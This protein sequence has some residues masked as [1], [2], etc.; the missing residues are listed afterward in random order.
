MKLEP[1]SLLVLVLLVVGGVLLYFG[2]TAAF[3]CDETNVWKHA[4]KFADFDFRSPGRP[5]LLWLFLAPVVWLKDPVVISLVMR[6]L[7]SLASVVTLVGVAAMAARRAP[8]NEDPTDAW[9][10]PLAAIVLGSTLAW[11][12]YAFELRT[13]TFVVPLTLAAMIQLYRPTPGVRR[14]LLAGCLIAAAGLVSQKS[15][16]NA[17]AIGLGWGVYVLAQ[18][19]PFGLKER[20]KEAVLVGG[21]TAVLMGSWF[22]MLTI[23]SGRGGAV[24]KHTFSVAKRTG[25]GSDITMETKLETL[26]NMFDRGPMLWVLAALAIP[27]VLATARRRPE[28]AAVTAAGVTM[29]ATIGIHRGYRTYYIASMLPLLAIPAGALLASLGGL[30]AKRRPVLSALPVVLTVAAAAYLTGD[31]VRPMVETSNAHQ[32]RVMREV[33]DAFDEPVPYLDLLGLVPGRYEVTFLGTGPQRTVFRSRIGAAAEAELGEDATSSERSKAR[34]YASNRA[35]VQRARD[36]LPLIFVRTYMSRDR[37]FKGPELKWYWKHYVPYRP[38][39][40]LHGGRMVVDDDAATQ[41]IELLAD[42]TYTVWFRGGWEGAASLDGQPL[43]HGTN[44]ELTA[45]RHEL[46]AA[47]T[48]GAGELQVIL[49]ADREP[50]FP[51]PRDQVDWSMFPHD[52]RDRYQHYDRKRKTNPADLLTPTWDPTVSDRAHRARL[53][54]HRK[55]QQKRQDSYSSP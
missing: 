6:L 15:V 42:G 28:I 11:H 24:V 53:K 9:A 26:G 25:F 31:F 32:L 14:A 39:V 7:A 37:Y 27:W 8:D 29:V 51:K 45:G 2:Q 13:D 38:N 30:L 20:A 41:G 40:Y 19:R 34:R 50:M 23:A 44:I 5:G 17:A 18:G 48:S 3:H 55:Y 46:S 10:G 16:Y 43:E 35:L 1:R 4:T 12:M 22:G 52:R 47:A 21:T 54:R 36:H 33:R 49:G